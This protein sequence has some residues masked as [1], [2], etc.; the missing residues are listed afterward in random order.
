[1]DDIE[2]HGWKERAGVIAAAAASL[3]EYSVLLAAGA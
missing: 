2:R 3:S 1:M